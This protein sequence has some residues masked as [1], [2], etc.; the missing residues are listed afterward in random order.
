MRCST[1]DVNL[2]NRG[3]RLRA[4]DVVVIVTLVVRVID[5]MERYR[6]FTEKVCQFPCQS[7]HESR[8]WEVLFVGVCVREWVSVFFFRMAEQNL[9]TQVGHLKA[10]SELPE[11]SVASGAW[12]PLSP[13]SR[14]RAVPTNAP[15]NSSSRYVQELAGRAGRDISQS[16]W[17]MWSLGFVRKTPSG[18][19]S[20]E[21]NLLLRVRVPLKHKGNKMRL[22]V[23]NSGI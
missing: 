1:S 9:S 18:I 17:N 7:S 6:A 23:Q 8:F 14:R 12:C 5:Q 10:S 16:S 2:L 15:P 21:K 19:C 3:R 22:T 20:F 13:P 4:N 11:Y